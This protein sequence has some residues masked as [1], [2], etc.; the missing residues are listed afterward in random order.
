MHCLF[1][2]QSGGKHQASRG[3]SLGELPPLFVRASAAAINA[4]VGCC[5]SYIIIKS[6]LQCRPWSPDRLQKPSSSGRIPQYSS[7][8][9]CT[10]VCTYHVYVQTP[11]SLDCWDGSY[12]PVSW[13]L[14]FTLPYNSRRHTAVFIAVQMFT[15]S[16][17]K[18]LGCIYLLYHCC[19]NHSHRQQANEESLTNFYMSPRPV[20]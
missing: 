11:A 7:N 16:Q 1:Q 10:Q 4:N 2:I 9:V 13:A 20:T 15:T 5:C 17:H 6:W 14:E 18:A 8:F 12:L 19:C 3:A